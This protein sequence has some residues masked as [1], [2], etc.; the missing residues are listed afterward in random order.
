M[1]HLPLIIHVSGGGCNEACVATHVMSHLSQ[2]TTSTSLYPQL[3]HLPVP[4]PPHPSASATAT[5]VEHKLAQGKCSS[6]HMLQTSRQA[7]KRS[8]RQCAS[9]TPQPTPRARELPGAYSERD[10]EERER[11]SLL[12]HQPLHAH[13]WHTCRCI[14]SQ[15]VEVVVMSACVCGAFVCGAC[16]CGACVCHTRSPSAS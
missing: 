8:S 14:T 1:L 12:L 5:Q 10:R 3:L 15:L 9:A 13:T 4:T 6:R 16:V 11:E 2:H 7:D